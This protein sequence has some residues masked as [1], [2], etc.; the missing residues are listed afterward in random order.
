MAGWGGSG[1]SALCPPRGA[2]LGAGPWLQDARSAVRH[3][4]ARGQVTVVA[5]LPQTSSAAVTV[6]DD[7]R[8]PAGS[9][10]QWR[11]AHLISCTF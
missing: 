3:R 5:L 4:H 11:G 9:L 1:G 2:L 8:V 6:G 7:G 10:R